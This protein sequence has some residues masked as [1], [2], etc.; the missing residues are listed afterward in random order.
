MCASICVVQYMC[1]SVCVYQYIYGSVHVEFRMHA[2][3]TCC[4]MLMCFN[5]CV[6]QYVYSSVHLQLNNMCA[7]ICA[8]LIICDSMYV[9]FRICV[10]L[11]CQSYDPAFNLFIIFGFPFDYEVLS[12]IQ[13]KVRQISIFDVL[14][15]SWHA[16]WSIMMQTL[17]RCGLFECT[18]RLGDNLKCLTQNNVLTVW[19]LFQT[20]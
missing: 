19:P 20:T 15:V 9:Q 12:Q 2:F 13:S 8:F 6:V 1:G 3:Y 14:S 18:S 5:V 17:M 7:S 16:N 10:V 4:S 11:A